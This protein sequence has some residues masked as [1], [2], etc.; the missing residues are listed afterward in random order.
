[1]RKFIT[2]AILF[3]IIITGA[4]ADITMT[5]DARVRPRLDI[6]DLGSYGNRTD[7]IYYFYRAR[8]N[9]AAD[10]GDGYFFKTKLG[11]NGAANFAKFGTGALP[12]GISLDNAGR[13]AISFMEVYF[14]HQSKTYGWAAGIIPVP[15]NPLL[16]MHYYPGK[17]GNIPWLLYNNAAASG[18]DFNYMLAGG[19]FDLKLL[20]DN[21]DGVKV[22][23]EGDVIDSLTTTDQYSLNASYSVPLAG[24]KVTPQFLMTIADEGDS[25]PMTYGAALAL[26]KVAGFGVSA[27]FGMTN[28]S[29]ENTNAYSGWIS[30][31]KLVGKL[32]PGALTAWYDMAVYT[33][34]DDSLE[35]TNTSFMWISYTYTLHKSD[36]GAVTLAPTYRL[37]TQKTEGILEYARSN[38]ELTTQIT[39]K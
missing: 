16:D 5:G 22:S 12:T 35:H 24:L 8:L 36:M 1:M 14:G 20:V 30:R 2:T 11:Y 9:I 17:M 39:F 28:Q 32:G 21:N 3:I 29:A 37:Y 19:K 7:N 10:I 25:A 18:F 15:H 4:Y 27:Y 23:S 38:I 33:P 34:D 26:P 13:S 31:A 6:V